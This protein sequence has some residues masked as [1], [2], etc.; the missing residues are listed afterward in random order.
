MST[1]TPFFSVIIPTHNRPELLPNA[2]KSVLAQKYQNFEIIVVNDASVKDYTDVEEFLNT[3]YRISYFILD[4]KNR[5]KTRNFGIDKAKGKWICFLDDDDIYYDNHLKELHQNILSTGGKYNIYHTF[6]VARKED[7]KLIK[8]TPYTRKK[9]GTVG[10]FEAGIPPIHTVCTKRKTL[11]LIKFDERLHFWEDMDLWLR[12]IGGSKVYVINKFTVE[13]RFHN[14]N[15]VND[16]SLNSIKQRVYSLNKLFRY[17][18]SNKWCKGKAKYHIILILLS[19]KKNPTMVFKSN[20]I[21]ML[22][23]SFKIYMAG[24]IF[25]KSVKITE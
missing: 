22:I 25:N 2:V 15:S 5:S 12:V 23:Q 4:N 21:Y 1:N 7:L 3:D 11:K 16:N 13:Y 20:S 9:R 19:L 24:N 8:H 6:S 17:N 14:D 18:G 10:L